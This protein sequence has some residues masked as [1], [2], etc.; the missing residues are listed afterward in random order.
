MRKR[1]LSIS[2]HRTSIALEDEFWQVLEEI[3][4]GRGLTLSRLVAE[5]DESRGKAS[6]SS[7]L[8]LLALGHCRKEAR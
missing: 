2:G 4:L 1:S 3:A 7:A 5:T 8:R 6:L